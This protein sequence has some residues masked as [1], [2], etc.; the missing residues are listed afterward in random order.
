[1]MGF[2]M[3]QGAG[4]WDEEEQSRLPRRVRMEG[5]EGRKKGG[6]KRSFSSHPSKKMWRLGTG[7]VHDRMWADPKGV[8]DSREKED[9]KQL[10]GLNELNVKPRR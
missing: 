4:K 10:N 2:A 1:M 5:P 9:G 6:G 7:S 3:R 8:Y